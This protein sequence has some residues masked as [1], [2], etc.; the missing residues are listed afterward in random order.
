MATYT[1]PNKPPAPV[2]DDLYIVNGKT[3]KW[4]GEAWQALSSADGSLRSQLAATDSTVLVGG[5]PAG[6]VGLASMTP[7]HLGGSGYF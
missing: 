1:Y 5:V 7:P 4:T 6:K 3:F 2:V